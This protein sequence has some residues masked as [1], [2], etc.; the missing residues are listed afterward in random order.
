MYITQDYKYAKIQTNLNRCHL[1]SSHI[2]ATVNNMSV[3]FQL[4]HISRENYF[5]KCTYFKISF[6]EIMATKYRPQNKQQ[7][8]STKKS[9]INKNENNNG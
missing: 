6:Y 4:Y 9:F 8:I 3:L 5:L 2:N 7:M 1:V